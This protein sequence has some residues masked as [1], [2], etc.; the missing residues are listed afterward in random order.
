MFFI[1]GI[2]LCTAQELTTSTAEV[3]SFDVQS[4]MSNMEDLKK[5]LDEVVQELY[6]LDEKER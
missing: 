6:A 5:N 2:S 3:S 1:G 4:A